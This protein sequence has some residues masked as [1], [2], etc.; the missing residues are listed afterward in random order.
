MAQNARFA[1]ADPKRIEA[2]IDTVAANP[3]KA[4]YAKSLLRAALT[5]RTSV[6]PFPTDAPVANEDEDLWDNVPV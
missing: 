4:N 3:E 5:G 2:L 1:A 6:V